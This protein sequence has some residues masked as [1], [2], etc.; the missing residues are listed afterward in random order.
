MPISV[1]SCLC[2]IGLICEDV[3]SP[4]N[5][6]RFNPDRVCGNPIACFGNY[7]WVEVGICVRD[8][9]IAPSNWP[10]RSTSSESYH[11]SLQISRE[12]GNSANEEGRYQ[13]WVRYHFYVHAARYDENMIEN[14][15]M[16][17]VQ[18]HNMSKYAGASSCNPALCA[19]CNWARCTAR[20]QAKNHMTGSAEAENHHAAR[21]PPPSL[22]ILNLRG[23]DGYFVSWIFS[24]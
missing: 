23:S 4:L 11:I 15:W 17:D 5:L 2:V 16:R 12:G 3:K 14:R 9:S 7:A 19:R 18:R 20:S 1:L 22:Q 13:L 8:G 6:P 21:P 24:H 10:P